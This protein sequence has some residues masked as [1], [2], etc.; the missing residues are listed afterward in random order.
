MLQVT[1]L[2]LERLAQ[3]LLAR[4]ASEDTALRFS[5]AEGRWEL[6]SDCARPRDA[7]FAHNGRNVLL[8]DE[9]ASKAMAQMT[10]DVRHTAAGPRL[11]LHKSAPGKD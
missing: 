11:K 1:S 6:R 3:K 9:A 2:A 7:A 5:R 10:L 8:L 4:K